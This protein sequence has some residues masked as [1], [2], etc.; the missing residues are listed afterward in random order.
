MLSLLV[1]SIWW[2][3]LL[4]TGPKKNITVSRPKEHG[5]VL[6][7]ALCIICFVLSKR[8]FICCEH[9]TVLSLNIRLGYKMYFVCFYSQLY[10][11]LFF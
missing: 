6:T 7:Y 10:F 1:V 5:H 8:I 4:D 2:S 3:I 9:R 11:P